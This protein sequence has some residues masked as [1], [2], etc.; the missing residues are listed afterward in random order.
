MAGM[1]AGAP[2]AIEEGGIVTIREAFNRSSL[3]G[4]A[5]WGGGIGEA[6]DGGVFAG[7]YPSPTHR[8]ATGSI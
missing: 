8:F 1:V 6:D 3:S 5:G 4:I 2:G 7:A